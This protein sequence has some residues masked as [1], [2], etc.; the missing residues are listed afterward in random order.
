[1][2]TTTANLNMTMATD[3]SSAPLLHEILTKSK[4]RKRQTNKD[5]CIKEE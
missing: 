2:P 5:C 1:M 4:Q 3:S